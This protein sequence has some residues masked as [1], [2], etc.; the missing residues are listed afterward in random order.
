MLNTRHFFIFSIVLL[1]ILFRGYVPAAEQAPQ[2]PVNQESDSFFELEP[3]APDTWVDWRPI[4]MTKTSF[5]ATLDLDS[6]ATDALTST[7]Y[8]FTLQDTSKY[9]GYAMNAGDKDDT[10]FDIIFRVDDQPDTNNVSYTVSTDG[11]IL[12]V[13]CGSPRTSLTVVVFVRDYG[14]HAILYGKVFLND[15]TDA[16]DVELDNT[17]SNND[18]DDD[19]I[20]I[21]RDNNGNDI[22]DGWLDDK[23]LNYDPWADE[24]MGPG[25]N[26]FQGDGYTVFE[27][28][29][30]FIVKGK[31][32]H[33]LPNDKDV[34]VYSEFEADGI[35]IGYASNLPDPITT[36]L[37]NFD[38]MNKPTKYRNGREV[39]LDDPCVMNLNKCSDLLQVVKQ[40]AL[41]IR[42]NAHVG[43]GWTDTRG[44]TYGFALDGSADPGPPPHNMK[45]IEIFYKNIESNHNAALAEIAITE[46]NKPD[47]QLPK[48][49]ESL[50]RTIGHE[51]GHGIGLYHPWQLNSQ[52]S[53][54]R[55]RQIGLNLNS[56]MVR[57]PQLLSLTLTLY[58]RE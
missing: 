39:W 53:P 52:R 27:E 30:G 40:R 28:Y 32:K 41:W 36:H 3:A 31:H 54:A 13:D 20:A 47:A 57:M 12:T 29:R 19:C 10:D 42:K 22:A 23:T 2:T 21:P 56:C 45:V 15:K 17:P 37:I 9:P 16:N 7:R 4:W 49:S 50:K 43:G 33:I 44:V 58:R 8:I 11:Q 26:T 51:F 6:D 34:F 38:E 5:V 46:P 48:L 55:G 18:D 1:S 35:G 24:E 14:A 25:N